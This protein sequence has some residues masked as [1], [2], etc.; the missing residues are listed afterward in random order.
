M[1]EILN[2]YIVPSGIL[3]TFIA[4]CINIY[5]TRKNLKTTKY[6]DVIT[7]ERIKWLSI[8]RK[9]VSELISLITETLIFY[10]NE[11]DD[12]E[13]QNPSDDYINDQNYKY[14][15]HYFD[16]LTK[17]AL[18]I[19]EKISFRELNTRLN[20]LKLRFNPNEDIQIISILDNFIT[21]Y[22]SEYK[23]KQDLDKANSELKLLFSN[24]QKMLK[25]EWEKVKSESKGN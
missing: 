13:S 8:I 14:Q 18:I 15:K 3:L 9:E 5:F 22:K 20:L 23:T 7:T 12:I 11:L 17:N 19:N 25:N 21:F 10:E 1:K 4:T 16:S 24:I 6:I 2:E